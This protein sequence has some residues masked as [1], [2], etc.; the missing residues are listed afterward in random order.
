RLDRKLLLLTTTTFRAFLFFLFSYVDHSVSSLIVF[1]FML[2]TVNLFFGPA[3]AATIP[4]IVSHE[5]LF[6]ANSM[7]MFTMFSTVLT[8][9]MIAGPLLG[10]LGNENIFLL[11][12]F[13]LLFAS[14]FIGKMPSV[15][16]GTK[17]ASDL[18]ATELSDIFRDLLAG[19]KYLVEHRATTLLPVLQITLTQALLSMLLV[20]AP[21]FAIDILNIDI[22]AS[23][24]LLI[25][26]GGVG[27]VVSL[28]WM[29]LYARQMS[30][31][32]LIVGGIL[33]AGVTLFLLTFFHTL[34]FSMVFLFF[35]GLASPLIAIPAQTQLQRNL[36]EE[37]RG[38]VYGILIMSVSVA[39]LLPV[40]ITG[41]LADL[42]G[43]VE[44]VFFV[45]IL[46][47]L[48]GLYNFQHHNG[49]VRLVPFVENGVQR[50]TTYV[51]QR[52]PINGKDSK[53]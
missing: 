15:G 51:S 48:F 33:L 36:S 23:S 16:N 25:G 38:R 5:Y 27:F 17:P 19:L 26:P 7:Y 21:G 44:V 2:S 52:F 12:G 11:L 46:T 10:V 31:A 41:F 8:G 18:F 1:S 43:I 42:F 6:A 40:A 28:I 50:L 34:L 14:F 32:R 24:Y 13:L 49:F 37:F 47:L 22:K 4:T 39:A 45:S 30:P 29:N 35:L 3:E 53:S 9:Y 20:I